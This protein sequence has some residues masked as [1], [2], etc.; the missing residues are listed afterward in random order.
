MPTSRTVSSKGTLT[1]AAATGLRQKIHRIHVRKPELSCAICSVMSQ[2]EVAIGAH[3]HILKVQIHVHLHLA[4]S[5][6]TFAPAPIEELLHMPA[7]FGVAKPVGSQF[8]IVR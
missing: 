7:L 2:D 4:H 3:A 5:L 8:E 1:V 6:A